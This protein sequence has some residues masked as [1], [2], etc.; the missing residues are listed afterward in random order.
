[1]RALVEAGCL[2]VAVDQARGNVVL[3]PVLDLSFREPSFGAAVVALG[4][5]PVR[6][7]PIPAFRAFADALTGAEL[8]PPAGMIAHVGRCGSTLLANLVGLGADTVVLKEPSVLAPTD[9]GL[10]RALLRFCRAVVAS[11]GRELVVKP[12][13]WT[14]PALLAAASPAGGGEGPGARWLLVWREPEAAVRSLCAT[15]PDWADS[16]ACRAELARLA[17]RV[18]DE[19]AARYAA[20]WSAI[21]DAFLAAPPSDVRFL[22]Y[23]ALTADKP[24]ALRR[25]QRWF[26]LRDAGGT[27]P[28]G[29]DAEAGRYSKATDGT[30]FDPAAAHHR[31]GLPAPDAELVAL[32]TGAARAALRDLPPARVL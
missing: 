14:C 4:S 19:P 16:P 21:V 28:A 13:S 5:R 18:P 31:P 32:G 20:H 7:V 1:M 8:G 22:D 3:C 26:G 15:P 23:R 6:L 12:T 27:L 9:P 10:A 30:R 11:A 25:T 29:F 17:G 24:D 2:P